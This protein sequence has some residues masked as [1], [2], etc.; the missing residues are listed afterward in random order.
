MVFPSEFHS[1]DAENQ[2]RIVSRDQIE[3]KRIKIFASGKKQISFPSGVI[4]ESYPN[5]Y[6]VI[7]FENC[8]VRQQWPDKRMVY[9]FAAQEITQTLLPS[10]IKVLYFKSGQLE[11]HAK[12]GSKQICFSDGTKRFVDALG[13]E[14]QI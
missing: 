14:V 8:D 9:Y 13:N 2:D 11:R 1:I 10:G 6:Q 4:R 7:Y 5:G 3:G 12:D